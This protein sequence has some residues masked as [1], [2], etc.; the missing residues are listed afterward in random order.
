MHSNRLKNI[1]AAGALTGLV[2]ATVIAFAWRDLGQADAAATDTQPVTVTATSVEEDV[3]ALQAENQQ[4]RD[5]LVTMQ[6][7]EQQYQTQ[8]EMANQTILQLQAGTGNTTGNSG[9]FAFGEHEREEH[10]FGEF[11]DD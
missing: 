5:A 11:G 4:L 10:E 7:R 1:L 9:S 8:L 3:N 2:L 6:E